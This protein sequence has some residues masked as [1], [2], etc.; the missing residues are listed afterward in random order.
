MNKLF[1]FVLILIAA[2]VFAACRS[3]NPTS[4]PVPPTAVVPTALPPAP[5]APALTDVPTAV[6]PTQAPQPTAIQVSPTN[7]PANPTASN[8]ASNP[9]SNA[10]VV[11]NSGPLAGLYLVGLRYDPTYPRNNEPLKFFATLINRTGKDQN[12]PVCVAIH[13]VGEPKPFGISSCDVVTIPPGT[14]E[15]SAGTWTGSGIKECLAVQARTVLKDLDQ[16]N[17]YLPM[18]TT[19]GA[20]PWTKFQ[21]CP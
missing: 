5:T 15:V 6:V 14:N 12:Y 18:T 4:T 20:S 17:V 7:A 8:D 9:T 13:R 21:V 16:D 3:N 19:S 2:S 11:V 10:P 1:A